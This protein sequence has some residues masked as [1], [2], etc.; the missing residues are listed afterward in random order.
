MCIYNY[1]YINIY[2][3]A[4]IYIYIYIHVYTHTPSSDIT[5]LLHGASFPEVELPPSKESQRHGARKHPTQPGSPAGRSPMARPWETIEPFRHLFWA[6][7][8]IQLCM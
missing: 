5:V 4:I 2:I 1:I 3:Y 6:D 8:F 7:R